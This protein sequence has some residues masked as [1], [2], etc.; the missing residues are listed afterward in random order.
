VTRAKISEYSATANDNTDVNGVDI[1]E[2][3]PPSSMNNMGREIMAALKRFQVGSDGDGVTVGGALV[4][5]G[6]TTIANTATLGNVDINGGTIDG[7]TIGGASAA[8]GTFTTLTASSPSVISVNS[9]SD[10]LRITQ[11]GA[12][13]ALLVEDSANPDATPFVIDNG[14]NVVVGALTRRSD[15]DAAFASTVPLQVEG[16]SAAGISITRNNAAA[17]S[18]YFVFAKSRGTALGAVTAVQNNDLLGSVL[19]EG[20]DGVGLVAAASISAAV[21]GTPGTNDMPGRLTFSTTADG[22]STPTERMRIDSAGQVGIGASPSAGRSFTVGKAITG[23]TGG[24]SVLSNGQTQSDVTTNSYGFRNDATTAAASFTLT[25]LHHFFANQGTFGAGSAVTTQYGYHAHS[26]LTGATNNYGFFS[27]IASGTG[28][29]NFYAN[30]T[31]DNYFAGNVGI[32]TTTPLTSLHISAGSPR[33]TLTDTDTGADHRINADSSVGNLAFDVDYNSEGSSPSCVFN[34]KG[35]E[36]MRIDSNGNLLVGTT[37][38]GAKFHIRYDGNA[39][40]GQVCDDTYASAGTNKA[41]QFKRNNVEVGTITMTTTATAFNTSSDYR[42]KENIA[43]MTGALTTVAQLKPCTYTWKS[44]GSAGQ[45]FIAHELQAVVPD[46]V[47]G[48]K[49]AV[50]ADGNPQYQG[51]DTSFLVATLTAAIQE[52]KAEL[53]EAKA[54]IAALE[55]A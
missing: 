26:T 4:V 30:G 22:A 19:F 7:T 35:T 36:R 50:D 49:D 54:R 34:I 3:C 41:I 38:A 42:L 55:Q 48:E 15:F 29:W 8:A 52:L 24:F 16:T 23:S 21:D 27:N 51:I 46:C 9:A 10:A 45:G 12:G 14:G 20:A 18:G 53:D 44:D 25:S 11:V 2:G 1:A 40:V 28:R 37:A 6:A 39:T 17:S 32:G 47:T 13:N 5:S 43:P 33:I 31:A